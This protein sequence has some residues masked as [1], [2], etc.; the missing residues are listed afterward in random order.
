MLARVA[1]FEGGDSERLREFN[2]QRMESG[3]LMLPGGVSRAMVWEE[4]SG[5]RLFI[6][7]FE[8]REALDAASEEFE[9][10]GDEMPES[11]RGRRVS[12]EIYDVVWDAEVDPETGSPAGGRSSRSAQAT[13]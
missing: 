9:R 5:R 10:M 12:V 6:T 3:E 11:A 8:S 4:P 2:E 7:L 1:S 13:S